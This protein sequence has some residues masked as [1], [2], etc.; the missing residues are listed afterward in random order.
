[1]K[2]LMFL[3]C[4]IFSLSVKAQKSEG[5]IR[6][7]VTHSWT[8]KMAALSY[9]S[10]QQKEKQQYMFA[11]RDEWKNYNLLFFNDKETKYINSDEKADPNDDGT[12]SGRSEVFVLQRNYE[13]NTRNDDI[14]ILSKTYIIEDTLAKPEWK[15]LNDIK[16]VA[17]HLCM[18]ATT[19]DSIRLEKIVA[20]FAMDMPLSGGPDRF[21]GL[22]G[23]ILEVDINDGGMLITADKIDIK[24]VVD[25]LSKTKKIK[26]KKINSTQYDALLN[27]HI[28]GKV[29]EEQYPYW[30]IGY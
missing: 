23:M 5:S 15:I 6:Y 27:D 10:K 4:F 21:Y 24:S 16:D 12:Y 9:I 22:P 1:M 3:F 17:G 26:G 2:Y 30:G 18:K 29:K 28:K 8:K 20:W 25:E 11:G 19:N 14:D 7:L 13:K